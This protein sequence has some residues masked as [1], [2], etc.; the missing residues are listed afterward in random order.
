MKLVPALPILIAGVFFISAAEAS[1]LRI[2]GGKET[3]L[4][5]YPFIT[6]LIGKGDIAENAFCGASVIA[7]QWALTAAHCLENPDANAYELIVN[8]S[9]L[10]QATAA[11]RVGVEEV[12]LHPA[13]DDAR[14]VNDIALLKLSSSV[15]VTSV[16][17]ATPDDTSAFAEGEPVSVAGWGNTSTSGEKYPTKLHAV[18]LNVSD[19]SDCSAAYGGLTNKH[20]CATVPGG[21]KDSCQGD[22]GGPL[23]ARTEDRIIQIGIVSFGDDCGSASHPGVYT[24]VSAYSDF[25]SQAVGEDTAPDIPVINPVPSVPEPEEPNVIEPSPVDP[26]PVEPNP[27]NPNPE[28]PASNT[29]EALEFAWV[30]TFEALM[31]EEQG[32]AFAELYNASTSTV[33]VEEF[34]ISTDSD[35]YADYDDCSSTELSPGDFCYVDLIWNPDGSAD[36]TGEVSI[37]VFDGAGSASYALPLDASVLK[38]VDFGDAVEMPEIDFYTTDELQWWVSYQEALVG[39]HAIGSNLAQSQNLTLDADL[40]WAEDAWLEFDYQLAGVNCVVYVEDEAE[41]VLAASDEWSRVSLPVPAGANVR[42]EFSAPGRNDA[43]RKIALD[44]FK[45]SDRSSTPNVDTQTVSS[46]AAMLTTDSNSGGGGSLGWMVLVSC[47]VLM[48]LRSAWFF[49]RRFIRDHSQRFGYL[50]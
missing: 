34:Q 40:N 19:F 41:Y 22:S 5:Q 50:W 7:P 25:L 24:R 46:E 48:I 35:V 45:R 47:W 1:N 3:Q 26:M 38:P 13:Y 43:F 49:N 32:F 20:L 16:D 36:L 33:V 28:Q 44:G 15:S 21:G 10:R 23:V 14:L 11:N 12:I 31:P 2:I 27:V 6:A 30:M 4:E 39:D 18:N 9:D 42:W 8:T 37:A 17:M 29:L